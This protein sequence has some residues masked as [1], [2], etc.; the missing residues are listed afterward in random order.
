MAHIKDKK[1]SILIPTEETNENGDRVTVW[2]VPL[3]GAEN[4]WAYYRHLSGRE[5]W[6]S[7]KVNAEEEVIFEINWRSGIDTFMRVLFRGAQ[8][9]ITNVD[10]FEGNKEDIKIYAKIVK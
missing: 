5:F 10:D 9:E 2:K 8:Y 3:T 1:V 6:A 7:Q 4:I